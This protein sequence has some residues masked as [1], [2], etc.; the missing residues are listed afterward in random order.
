MKRRS[1][2]EVGDGTNRL[3][4]HPVIGRALLTGRG[5][6]GTVMLL[7]PRIASRHWLGRNN[8][9]AHRLVRLVGLR[10]LVLCAGQCDALLGSSRRWRQLG[11]LADVADGVVA[12]ATARRSQ[13]RA[14]VAIAAAAFGSTALTML[15]GSGQQRRHA[16]DGD[17]RSMRWDLP[18]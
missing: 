6:A 11:A 13:Q 18:A 15:A 12:V 17:Q 1:R 5:G 14:A 7:A 3:R 8:V 16:G 4:V 10:D 2:P 9:D